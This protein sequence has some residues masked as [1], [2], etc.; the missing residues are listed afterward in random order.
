MMVVALI[1]CSPFLNLVS[2]KM[3]PSQ[4][5]QSKLNP[6]ITRLSTKIAKV[7]TSR[8]VLP[9]QAFQKQQISICLQS[10]GTHRLLGYPANA[11]TRRM[12]EQAIL[13]Q[14]EKVVAGSEK[15]NSGD[16]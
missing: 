3:R 16:R 4:I 1:S 2:G 13:A 10:N 9:D 15:A 14:Y 11:E 12:I 8:R 6:T 5:N 7:V